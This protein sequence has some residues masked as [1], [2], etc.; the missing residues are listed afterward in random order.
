M[1]LNNY[2]I[3]KKTKRKFKHN[4]TKKIRGRHAEPSHFIEKFNTI[5]YFKHQ[6][7]KEHL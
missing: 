1:K 3:H 2:M 6:D 7:H 4:R 5:K